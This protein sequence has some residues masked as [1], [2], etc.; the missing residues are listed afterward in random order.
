M[1]SAICLSADEG[2]LAQTPRLRPELC[3]VRRECLCNRCNADIVVVGNPRHVL[4]FSGFWV[5]PDSLGNWGPVW[6]IIEARSGA[7]TLIVH[8]FAEQSLSGA[9]VDNVEVWNWYDA[10]IDSAVAMFRAGRDALQSHLLPYAGQRIGTEV[11]WFPHDLL[12][13]QSKCH[14]VTDFIVGM[15]RSKMEDELAMIRHAVS[16]ASAGY[17]AGRAAIS[18]GI[19]EIELYSTIIKAMN[20]RAGRSVLLI[21][22]ILSGPRTTLISGPATNRVIRDGESVI[23][24]LSPIVHGYRVDFAGT[25]T[26][27]K[28]ST[29]D[30]QLSQAL[31]SAMTITE[32]ELHPGAPAKYVYSCLRAKMVEAGFG[33][34]FPH[35]AGHGLGLCHP[36]APYFVPNSSETLVEGD[37]V[38]LEPGAYSHSACGRIEH[39][40]LINGS[41]AARLTDHDT[42]VRSD[43]LVHGSRKE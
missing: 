43:T 14:D 13:S 21:A 5:P 6:L 31:H 30:E 37:V 28:A 39:M 1:D 17:E 36:E 20:D 22:D 34:A 18:A 35:H 27:G 3:R 15:R 29:I 11:G 25:L 2:F 40:Y 16:V 42:R 38:T 19:S 23:V 41:G 26:A 32:P 9:S 8:N 7:S 12:E 4:Y 24:D 10:K 33:D